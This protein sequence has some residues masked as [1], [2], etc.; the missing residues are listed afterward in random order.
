MLGTIL[1][2]PPDVCLY[3]M[4]SIE[5]WHL[6]ICLDPY[7][8]SCV[9]SEVRKRGDVQAEFTRL[10]ELA[11]ELLELEVQQRLDWSYLNMSPETA[12][13]PSISRLPGSPE[14]IGRSSIENFGFGR[15]I[16]R[17]WENRPEAL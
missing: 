17:C 8:V 11:W 6:T 16:G 10:G 14:T 1:G 13:Y 15:R 12:T 3:N 2:P 9:F 4:P 5:E 7:F